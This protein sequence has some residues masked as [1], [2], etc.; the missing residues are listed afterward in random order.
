MGELARKEGRADILIEEESLGVRLL[1]G[2]SERGEEGDLTI[3]V[4]ARRT[5][6]DLRGAGRAVGVADRHRSLSST[7]ALAWFVGSDMRSEGREEA[8]EGEKCERGDCIG[9]R[10]EEGREEIGGGEENEEIRGQSG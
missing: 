9:R 8:T 4:G 7:C 3:I 6:G 2:R 1:G 10:R 5:D